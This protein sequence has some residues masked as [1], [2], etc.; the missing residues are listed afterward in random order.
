MVCRAV[1]QFGR[2]WLSHIINLALVDMLVEPQLLINFDTK[3][4]LLYS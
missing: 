4:Y 2:Q 3:V 1:T